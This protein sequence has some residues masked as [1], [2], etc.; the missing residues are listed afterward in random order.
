MR[1]V[2][3]AKVTWSDPSAMTNPTPPVALVPRWTRCQSPA[4]PSVAEY[5]HIGE[6]TILFFRV[7]FFIVRGE[8]N[9]DIMSN[10]L[11]HY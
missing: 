1:I 8:N 2:P 10:I 4:K 5:W 9:F 11:K 3:Q 7:I 6:V